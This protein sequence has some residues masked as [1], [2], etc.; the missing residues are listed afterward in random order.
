MVLYTIEKLKDLISHGTLAAELNLQHYIY[1]FVVAST[2]FKMLDTADVL[3]KLLM[4]NGYG[5]HGHKSSTR[6]SIVANGDGESAGHIYINIVAEDYKLLYDESR[7]WRYH[8]FVIEDDAFEESFWDD[9]RIFVS[10][11]KTACIPV[12]VDFFMENIYRRA[13][14]G[15]FHNS[16]ELDIIF[17]E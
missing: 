5:C 3:S 14:F 10:N 8:A 9:I 4:A 17:N 12:S 13:A 6:C 15:K 7:M 1:I 11:E 16:D 2:K